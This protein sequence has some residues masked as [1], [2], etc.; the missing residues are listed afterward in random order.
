MVSLSK[1]SFAAV[2]E[3]VTSCLPEEDDDDDD[4]EDDG[5]GAD[6]EPGAGDDGAGAVAHEASARSTSVIPESTLP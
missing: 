5:V 3:M 4:E 1:A 2:S 6:V